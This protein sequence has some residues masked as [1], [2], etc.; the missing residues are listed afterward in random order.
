[1]QTSTIFVS[2]PSYRDAYTSAT[3]EEL[4]A[5]ASY[6]SRIF[7]GLLD[8][9]KD[10]SE[11][12]KIPDRW[13]ANVRSLRVTYRE[14]RGPTFARYLIHRLFFRG[15]D[16]FFQIDSHMRFVQNWD[17]KLIDMIQTIKDHNLS[18]NPILS[19][20]PEVYEKHDFHPAQSSKVTEIKNVFLNPQKIISY[21]GADY[22]TP[23]KVPMRNPFISGNMMFMESRAFNDFAYDPYLP[24]LFTGE[25]ILMSVRFFTLGWDVF[26]PNENI[27]Y[28]LYTRSSSPKYWNDL[29]ALYD[30]V[31]NVAT[32]KARL[33]LRMNE[34]DDG[35]SREEMMN[36]L[37]PDL[38]A[39]L[40]Q[41]DVGSKRSLQEYYD[42]I[43]FDVKTQTFRFQWHSRPKK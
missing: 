36:K 2:I 40:M 19:H 28:H 22:V 8:Q 30:E 41:Y 25:E 16:F 27:V 29:K 21:H 1:M 26:T 9:I 42:W 24:Y 43:G 18:H 13:K 15:E 38:K 14:S 10:D 3:I 5:V 11:A 37:P 31:S 39:S 35:G 17:T 12:S 34:K 23:S 32:L 6:P 7:V 4:F 33:I 20:Y